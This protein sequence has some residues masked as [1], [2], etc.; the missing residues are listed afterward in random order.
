MSATKRTR[1]E[2]FSDGVFAIAG[3]VS[4]S[5]GLRAP[6]TRSPRTGTPRCTAPRPRARQYRFGPLLYVLLIGVACVSAIASLVLN[7]ILAVFFGFPSNWFRR[8]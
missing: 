7:L 4:R 1:V 5:S 2:A 6:G 3:A 8:N